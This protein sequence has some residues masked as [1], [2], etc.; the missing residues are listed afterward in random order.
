MHPRGAS[1][2]YSPVPKDPSTATVET[3]LTSLEGNY[4]DLD[5]EFT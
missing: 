1:P 4:I 2:S 3:R 5:A